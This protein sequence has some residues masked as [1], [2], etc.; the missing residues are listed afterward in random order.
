M[1]LLSAVVWHK[2]VSV[3]MWQYLHVLEMRW[4]VCLSCLCDRRTESV[5]VHCRCSVDTMMLSLALQSSLSWIWLCRA[6]RYTSLEHFVCAHCVCFIAESPVYHC[7]HTQWCLISIYAYS[8]YDLY[9]SI[10]SVYRFRYVML[11]LIPEWQ[12]LE[13]WV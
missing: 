1:H 4:I 13:C 7:Y 3:T 2:I 12:L 9:V 6:Q 10:A 11:I 5:A 8:L